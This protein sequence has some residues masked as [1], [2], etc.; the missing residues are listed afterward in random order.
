[1]TPVEHVEDELELA[2]SGLLGE[3]GQPRDELLRRQLAVAVHVEGVE[4]LTDGLVSTSPLYLITVV[5]AKGSAHLLRHVRCLL[6]ADA[7]HELLELRQSEPAAPRH[8]LVLALEHRHVHHDRVARRRL[9]EGCVVTS[10]RPH[11]FIT[12]TSY[13]KESGLQGND[14]TAGG[15]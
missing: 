9:D 10:C 8:A 2:P 6:E 1:M 13:K 7:R 5:T 12:D 15:S 4:E 14:V 11:F 3:A